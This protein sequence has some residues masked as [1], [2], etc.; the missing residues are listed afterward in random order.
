MYSI[1][2]S[3]ADATNFMFSSAMISSSVLIRY[4]LFYSCT[5]LSYGSTCIKYGMQYNPIVFQFQC[6]ILDRL[7]KALTKSLIPFG[8]YITWVFLKKIPETRVT[9]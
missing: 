9:G 2:S 8:T 6:S 7:F 5:S 3:N 4:L 1:I